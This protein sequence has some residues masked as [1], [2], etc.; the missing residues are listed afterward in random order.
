MT[1]EKMTRVAVLV[2]ATWGFVAALTPTSYAGSFHVEISTGDLGQ[3][4][5]NANAPFYLDFQFNDGGVLGNNS[6]SITN[7]SFTGGNATGSPVLFGGA[8]GDLGSNVQ[9]NNSSSFQELYQSFSPGATIGFDVFLTQNVD[10]ITPDSF[11]VSILDAN[12]LNIPASGLGDSLVQIDLNSSGLLTVNLGAGTGLYAGVTVS[13][14]AVP[15]PG[16]IS[17]LGMGIACIVGYGWR[18][19][20]QKSV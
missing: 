1:R 20:N 8:V 10:G 19:R 18:R 15:E 2:V 14:V 6:A 4:P 5:A 11:F 9:F 7:L 17:M 3:S 12:L 16:S 13:A